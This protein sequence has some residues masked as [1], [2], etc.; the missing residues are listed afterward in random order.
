MICSWILIS[1]STK[2]P[3]KTELEPPSFKLLPPP[4]LE[5]FT[6]PSTGGKKQSIT[7]AYYSKLSTNE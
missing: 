2:N 4:V 5:P 1:P 6:H 7:K 3:K